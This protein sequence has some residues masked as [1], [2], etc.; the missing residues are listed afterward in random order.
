MKSNL[1]VI[2]FRKIFQNA[3]WGSIL[4]LQI[5]ASQMNDFQLAVKV[6]IEQLFNRK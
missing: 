6:K 1:T 5:K 2:F 4:T 3:I